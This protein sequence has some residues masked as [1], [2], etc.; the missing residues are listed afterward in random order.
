MTLDYGMM[1]DVLL[2]ALL[3]ATVI[4][5]LRLNRHLGRVRQAQGELVELVGRFNQATE[6]ARQSIADLKI[7]GNAAGAELD[8]NVARARDVI[9]EMELIIRSGERVAERLE[10]GVS[11]PRNQ[12]VEPAPAPQAAPKPAAPRAAA[13]SPRKPAVA[14]AENGSADTQRGRPALVAERR[15]NEARKD[16]L[17]SLRRAR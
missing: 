11:R 1:L 9:E 5:C 8:R 4:F 3:V 10:A 15:E 16:L 12:T 13:P 17:S 14:P 6:D 7:A 2:A